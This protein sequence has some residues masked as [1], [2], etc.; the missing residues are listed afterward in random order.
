MSADVPDRR[1]VSVSLA[2]VAYSYSSDERQIQIHHHVEDA[3]GFGVVR[4]VAKVG[5][6]RA[7]AE[8]F[9]VP[10]LS[11]LDDNGMAPAFTRADWETFKREADQ[12]F[13]AFER[14]WPSSAAAPDGDRLVCTCPR[15]SA[16]AVDPER[17]HREGCPRFGLKP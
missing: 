4:T 2:P 14:S 1:V 12:A 11:L 7:R 15:E 6:S 3:F 16:V 10:V 9:S 13:D 8:A 5:S 17:P